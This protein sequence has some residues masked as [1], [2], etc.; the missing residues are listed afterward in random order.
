MLQKLIKRLYYG[1][2]NPFLGGQQGIMS[3]Q[4]DEEIVKNDIVRLLLTIPGERVFRPRFGTR[5]RAI[6]FDMLDASDLIVIRNEILTAISENDERVNIVNLELVMNDSES[7]L[8]VKLVF[9]LN[10]NPSV[11]YFVGLGIG[12]SSITTLQENAT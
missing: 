9:N 2:N 11:N 7:R 5:L 8:D 3:T 6:V 1:W 4:F 12:T 10:G